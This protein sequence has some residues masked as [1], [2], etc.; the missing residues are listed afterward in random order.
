M[1]KTAQVLEEAIF[2]VTDTG[3][4][5]ALLASVCVSLLVHAGLSLLAGAT[6]L[7]GLLLLGLLMLP[8]FFRYLLQIL[9]ARAGGRSVPVAGLELFDVAGN[10]WSL[11]PCVLIAAGVW[12]LLFGSVAPL[13][14]WVCALVF[15]TVL[16][17]SL[18]VLALTHS[19][20]ESLNPAALWRMMKACGRDFP[21]IPLFP[22]AAGYLAWLAAGTNL[23]D[24]IAV[25]LSFYGVFLL[26]TF[27]GAVLHANGVQLLIDIPE[28]TEVGDDVVAASRT[29]ARQQVLTHA[30]GF[31]SRNNAAG[32]LAHIESA[33]Q[34]EIDP[35]D[36]YQWYFRQMLEWESK[37]GALR[38]GQAWLGRLLQQGREVE[39]L[40]LLTRCVGVDPAF[41]PLPD[42]R[43]AA[44]AT[45]A[46]HRR[47]DL[48]KNLA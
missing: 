44:R 46:R 16:P 4:L 18:A 33:A 20:L 10:F 41:R 3:V 38:L 47:D 17:A 28:P 2:P 24:F 42:D 31:F 1:M 27:T 13:L 37:A 39:A 22:V 12:A 19:P 35:D 34:Q 26:F 36:A 45:A 15:V 43:E 29:R 48:M 25:A 32:G 21:L 11:T 5:L 30:Y 9:E 23:P 6:G 8:A 14:A 7:T 40:K